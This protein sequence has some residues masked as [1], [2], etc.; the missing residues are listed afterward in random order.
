MQIIVDKKNNDIVFVSENNDFIL[1]DKGLLSK[2]F[3]AS[4]VKPDNF[5]LIEI[6]AFNYDLFV[7]RFFQYIDGNIVL[8]EEKTKEYNDMVNPVPQKITMRRA[9]L[10]LFDKN[11]L[12]SVQS[13]IDSLEEPEKTKAQIEWDFSAEVWRNKPFVLDIAQGLG[14]TDEELDNLFR[15]AMDS[16]YD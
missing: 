2:T 9:R 12:N 14:W 3:R 8:K 16:K 15:E 7:G 13:A 5:E 6:S 11:L 1:N 4:N 10:V